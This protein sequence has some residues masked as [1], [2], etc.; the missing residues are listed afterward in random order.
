MPCQCGAV[1][2]ARRCASRMRRRTPGACLRRMWRGQLGSPHD[3]S[4]SASRGRG[5]VVRSRKAYFIPS[6]LPAFD[7]ATCDKCGL[8]I[9][10][11]Q[12]GQGFWNPNKRAHDRNICRNCY[13]V[14]TY[15]RAEGWRRW[16]EK[17]AEMV[18][19]KSLGA[20]PGAH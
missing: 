14:L 8:L 12:D 7:Y 4:A 6:K 3:D 17:H 18:A 9:K 2:S 16:Q 19:V 11:V 1:S 10:T 5:A 15:E 13:D 20:L